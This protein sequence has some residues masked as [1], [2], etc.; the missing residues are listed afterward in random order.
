VSRFLPRLALA[1]RLAT[2]L[3]AL[4]A[5]LLP[6]ALVAAATSPLGFTLGQTTLAEVERSVPPDRIRQRVGRALLELDPAAFDFDGLEQV[7]LIFNTAEQHLAMVV[8]TIAKRRFR[9]VLA[10]L[11]AKYSVDRERIDNFMQNGEALFRSGDDWI[12]LEA[13]HLS[14]SIELTYATD[15]VWREM[16]RGIEENKVKKRQQERG[17]L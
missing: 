12:H 10:D 1:P 4:A 2:L 7:L 9:D 8:L 3:L 15:E 17:K 14:F 6:V 11:R 16:V 5:T 13:P